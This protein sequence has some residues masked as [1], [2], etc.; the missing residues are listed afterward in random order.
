MVNSSCTFVA[1]VRHRFVPKPRSCS[2]VVATTS[3]TRQEDMFSVVTHVDP[4]RTNILQRLSLCYT[5]IYFVA[6]TPLVSSLTGS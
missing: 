6:L 4:Q 2:M 3:E 1:P 5:L